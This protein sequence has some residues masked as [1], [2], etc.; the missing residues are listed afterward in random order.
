MLPLFLLELCPAARESTQTRLPEDE[1]TC[2]T[3]VTSA[4]VILDWPACSSLTTGHRCCSSPSKARKNA[5]LNQ[6][7]ICWPWILR[8]YYFMD[9]KFWNYLLHSKSSQVQKPWE[10]KNSGTRALMALLE[11]CRRWHSSSYLSFFL[12][13]AHPWV[14]EFD[15][16]ALDHVSSPRMG[17]EFTGLV[18]LSEP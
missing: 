9:E 18:T 17:V 2:W 5:Q 7:Q 10:G 11:R 14:K 6:A 4:E 15:W 1:T 13:P 12:N 8:V 16:S 3:E